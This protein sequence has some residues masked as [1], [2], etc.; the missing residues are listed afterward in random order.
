MTHYHKKCHRYSKFKTHWLWG[1]FQTKQK[2]KHQHCFSCFKWQDVN[3][4]VT[5]LFLWHIN[6]RERIVKG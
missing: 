3:K 6:I 2:F 4:K 5:E 1:K